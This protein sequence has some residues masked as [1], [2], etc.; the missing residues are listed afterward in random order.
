[1]AGL[2]VRVTVPPTHIY[3]LLLGAA[4][5]V[6][7]TVTVVVYTVAGAQP[8]CVEPSLTVS[9]YIEDTD[10]VAV[11]LAI[12]VAESAVPVQLKVLAPPAGFAKKDTVPPLQI[13]LLLVGVAIGVLFTV[14][15]VV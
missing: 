3:P 2:A 4:V 8:G 9:E 10:G 6:V 5:G 7:L 13:G 1:L 11:G 15:E 12:V 14:T